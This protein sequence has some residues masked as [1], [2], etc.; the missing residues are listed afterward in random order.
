M[1]SIR[2]NPQDLQSLLEKARTHGWTPE[3]RR[4]QVISFAYG[5]VKLH[6]PA[7]TREDVEWIYEQLFEDRK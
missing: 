7:I 3:Q 2:N 1:T 6:N 4:A 5:N